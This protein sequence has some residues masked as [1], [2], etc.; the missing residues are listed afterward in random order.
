[1]RLMQATR[2][3]VPAGFLWASPLGH[4]IEARRTA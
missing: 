2:T 1:M 3:P 4:Q